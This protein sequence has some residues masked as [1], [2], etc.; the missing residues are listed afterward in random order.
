MMKRPRIYGDERKCR[1]AVVRYIGAA[2][3]LLDQ[4]IGVGKRIDALPRGQRDSKLSALAAEQGWAKD[5]RRWF[6]KA[7]RAVGPYLQEQFHEVLPVLA[8]GLPPDT[9]KS[10]H[11]IALDNGV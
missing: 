11:A 1:A 7:Q 5:V 9:G 8:L 3:E 4:A 2:E 10:R 6:G